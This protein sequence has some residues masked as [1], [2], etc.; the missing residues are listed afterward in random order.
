MFL[1][2]AHPDIN[3]MQLNRCLYFEV[4]YGLDKQCMWN[5]ANLTVGVSYLE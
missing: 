3:L 5:P 1:H 2:K 4:K